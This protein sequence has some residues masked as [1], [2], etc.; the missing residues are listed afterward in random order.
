MKVSLIP[1]DIEHH[2]TIA[3]GGQS[4]Y[5]TSFAFCTKKDENEYEQQH[6]FFRCRDIMFKIPV[7]DRE[8]DTTNYYN[9]LSYNGKKTPLDHDKLRLL[10]RKQGYKV[11]N[12]VMC[13][14]PIPWTKSQYKSIVKTLEAVDGFLGNKKP[15][16]QDVDDCIF[17]LE[18]DS[19]WLNCGPVLHLY[20]TLIRHLTDGMVATGLRITSPQSKEQVIACLQNRYGGIVKPYLIEDLQELLTH[21][22]KSFNGYKNGGNLSERAAN[23]GMNSY[24][25]GCSYIRSLKYLDDAGKKA[26]VVEDYLKSLQEQRKQYWNIVNKN[27]IME[28]FVKKHLDVK[29]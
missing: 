8:A 15:Q 10:V 16:I 19:K 22:F 28:Y 26:G 12:G 7:A 25:N 2:H 20:T 21:E 17:L 3:S 4:T 13:P 23:S 14:S 18:A 11:K 9:T 29:N 1:I 24:M 5:E 6:I 27:D